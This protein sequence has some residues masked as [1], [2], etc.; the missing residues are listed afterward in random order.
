VRPSALKNQRFLCQIFLSNIFESF[1]ALTLLSGEM[2][3]NSIQPP[4]GEIANPTNVAPQNRNHPAFDWQ[5]PRRRAGSAR[6][7]QHSSQNSTIVLKSLIES[8]CFYGDISFPPEV[9]SSL[10][11][12]NRP[13][14][15]PSISPLQLLDIF[16]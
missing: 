5:R 12:I 6:R 4:E 15:H 2:G 16:A 11:D 14:Q 8:H 1:S 7:I 10:R 9:A 3:G 13:K